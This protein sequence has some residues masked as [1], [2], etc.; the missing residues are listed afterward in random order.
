MTTIGPRNSAVGTS[1]TQRAAEGWS[2]ATAPAADQAPQPGAAA[3]A[4]EG[5]LGLVADT[6]E[7]AGMATTPLLSSAVA[8]G[9]TAAPAA[10]TYGP[11]SGQ[12]IQAEVRQVKNPE[13]G[14]VAMGFEFD[15]PLTRE[16]AAQV[17]FQ[18]G[19]VPAGAKLLPGDKP[20]SW[21]VASPDLDTH[22]ATLRKMNSRTETTDSSKPYTAKVSWTGGP[23]VVST[24]PRRNDLKNDFGFVVAKHYPLDPGQTPDRHVKSIVGKGSGY[25]LAFDKPM[26]K[27]QVMDKLF[28]QSKFEKGDVKLIPVGGPPS[29]TWRVEIVGPDALGAVKHPM[30]RAFEDANVYAK[31]SANPD[32]PKGMKGHFD[33]KTVPPGAKHHPPSTYV[34]EQDGHIAHVST[35]GKGNYSYEFTKLHPTEESLNK[36]IR[37]FMI[38]KGM[39][40]KE[41]WKAFSEHW[42]D[43]H[44]QMLMAFMGTLAGGRMPGKAP[45]APTTNLP[46]RTPAAKPNVSAGKPSVRTG[47]TIPGHPPPAPK[48][49]TGGAPKTQPDY[50]KT[51]TADP[52]RA[53]TQTSPAATQPDHGKTMTADPGRAA[54]QPGGGAAPPARNQ[55]AAAGGKPQGETV[56]SSGGSAGDSRS[57]GAGGPKTPVEIRSNRLPENQQITVRT[58]NGPQK[59]TVGEY[60]QRHAQA[61]K[62]MSE[63]MQKYHWGGKGPAPAKG[64]LPPNHDQL[65]KQAQEK[66]GLDPGWQSIGNPFTHG[67]L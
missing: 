47:D 7:V 39:A 9:A 3:A 12:A 8:A 48:V 4:G 56:A 59:M 58:P 34:W 29:L 25:E 20:T 11:N 19:Q 10:T 57:Q 37:Y 53:R 64:S 45:K 16:Q 52:G 46:S 30:N 28:D 31:T 51:M 22:Q 44:R 35:D 41:G 24:G 14:G 36:T 67:R 63:Q 65:S 66:F 61:E 32:I 33:A 2:P 15:R 38:E 1:T 5:L 18:G 62:W 27:Q 42:D 49:G 13:G 40:P 43:I 6:F 54:T 17:L 50:G 26:T 21:I 23:N 60:R 55:G